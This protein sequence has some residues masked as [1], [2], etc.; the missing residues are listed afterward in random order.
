MSC[1]TPKQKLVLDYITEYSSAHAYAPSQ[2]EIAAKFGFKSL[3]TVQHYLVRLADHGFLLKSWN[4]RRGLQ[5]TGE[6]PNPCTLSPSQ[7][8]SLC[9]QNFTG[10]KKRANDAHK[11]RSKREPASEISSVVQMKLPLLGMVAAGQPIEAIER[12]SHLSVPSFMVKDAGSHFVLQV[13]GDSMVEEGIFE[14][15]Y[16]VFKKQNTAFNGQTVVALINNEATIKKYFKRENVIEL[17]PANS[18]YRP[19]VVSA[20]SDFRIEGILAGVIRNIPKSG[21][22]P[23][24]PA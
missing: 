20:S 15:D 12:P 11:H 13:K 23:A 18:A 4:A 9:T 17:H 10:H 3:G 21:L 2:H 8:P 22:P 16:V 6:T 7:S 14:G 24:K 1:L 19:I 5:V